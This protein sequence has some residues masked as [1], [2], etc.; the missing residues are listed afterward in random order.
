MLYGIVV[1]YNKNYKESRSFRCILESDLYRRKGITVIATDNSTK[2]AGNAPCGDL[3]NVHYISMGGNKGISGAY[4][5]AID[6]IMSVCDAELDRVV[7][8]DDDTTIPEEY[9]VEIEKLQG[10]DADVC[11]P[12]VESRGMIVSPCLIKRR[13][14]RPLRSREELDMKKVSAINTAMM[15]KAQIFRDYRYDENIFLDYVDH[16]FMRTMRNGNKRF[17]LMDTVIQQD[18][19]RYSDEYEAAE[20]RFR[21]FKKDLKVYYKKERSLLSYAMIIAVRRI[22]MFAQYKKF[23]VFFI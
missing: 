15:I 1:L 9:F 6:Y 11:F 14:A 22:K 10:N 17:L 4:N 20:R 13:I 16:D 3:E 5:R 12:L 19:S 2:D 18:F 7:L 21:I 23:K 8:F